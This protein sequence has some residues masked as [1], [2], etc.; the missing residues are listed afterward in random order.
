MARWLNDVPFYHDALEIV[1]EKNRHFW[2]GQQVN[3]SL[4]SLSVYVALEGRRR[5]ISN[6]WT[7]L[8][9]AQLVNLSYAQN[10]FF[11]AVLLTPVPL[12]ENVSELTRDSVPATS[13]RSDDIILPNLFYHLL[14]TL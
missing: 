11:I 3:L 6:L 10:L 1:A 13:T 12:P 9:L 8:A 7:F 2:W 5:N 14:N 4:V